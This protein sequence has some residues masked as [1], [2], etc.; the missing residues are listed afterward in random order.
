MG[1]Y[2]T[3][4]KTS[5]IIPRH[6]FSPPHLFTSQYLNTSYDMCCARALCMGGDD[7]DDGDDDSIY[8]TIA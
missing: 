3:L 8:C 7:Y 5:T 1:Q 6:Y 4:F 2:L